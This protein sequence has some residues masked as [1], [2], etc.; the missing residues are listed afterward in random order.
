MKIETMILKAIAG[1]MAWNQAAELLDSSPRQ[2]RRK[3]KAYA[4][5]G[6]NSLIDRRK[7]RSKKRKPK[8]LVDRILKLYKEKY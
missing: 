5:E 8:A 4:E 3:R 7:G 2:L 1:E 6:I